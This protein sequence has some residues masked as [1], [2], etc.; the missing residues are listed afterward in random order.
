MPIEPLEIQMARL[1]EQLK[2]VITTLS[3]DREDRKKTDKSLTDISKTVTNLDRRLENVEHQLLQNEPTI[4]DFIRI[5]HQV[6]G[7]GKL[8][9]LVWFVGGALIAGLFTSRETIKSFFFE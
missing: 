7:A 8:G 3:E 5:K 9:R 4:Q 2:A 1:Q 6:Q